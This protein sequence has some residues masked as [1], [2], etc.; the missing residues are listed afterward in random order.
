MSI[1]KISIESEFEREA[2]DIIGATSKQ[3][4]SLAKSDGVEWDG[5]GLP[6]VGCIVL[7]SFHYDKDTAEKWCI[8]YITEQV[9]VYTIVDTGDQYTFATRDVVF[10]KPETPEQKAERE[11]LDLVKKACLTVRHDYG[12]MSEADRNFLEKDGLEWLKAFEKEVARKEK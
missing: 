10:H 9:G 11:R 4:E 2:L 6:P 12:L 3:V 1:D 7:G 8:D 5:S